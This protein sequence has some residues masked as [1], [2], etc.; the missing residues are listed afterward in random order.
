M[1]PVDAA[2]EAGIG[3]SSRHGRVAVVGVVLMGLSLALWVV[4]PIV[5]FLPID[6]GMKATV[7]GSQIVVAEVAFWLGAALAGPEAARRMKSWWRS[8]RDEKGGTVSSD[9]Q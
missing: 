6:V 1:G 9:G 3:K 2:H 8:S 7:A 5:P 4:L